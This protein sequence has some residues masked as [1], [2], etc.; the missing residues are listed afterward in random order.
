MYKILSSILLSRFTPYAE[1]IICDHRKDFDEKGHILIVYSVFIKYAS[2]KWEYNETVHQ[3]FIGFKKACD[4]EGRACII[5]TLS[6]IFHE[7]V[8]AN[9]NVSE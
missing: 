1:E 4:S 5:F 9:T 3:L 8:K 6:L 2:K 7:T